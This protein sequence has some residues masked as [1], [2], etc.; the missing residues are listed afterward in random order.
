MIN[1]YVD[2][3]SSSLNKTITEIMEYMDDDSGRPSADLREFMHSKIAEV[4][5][6]WAMAGFY[7]GHR[8]SYRALKND[9]E[10]PATLEFDYGEANLAPGAYQE[11]T[12]TSRIRR[13]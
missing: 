3:A 8:E 1:D 9:G 6:W 13:T 12:L 10:I 11:L 2:G 5:E 7:L 4:S